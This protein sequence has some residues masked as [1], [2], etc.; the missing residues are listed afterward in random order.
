MLIILVQ[1][2][3]GF[4]FSVQTWGDTS[5]DI[6]NGEQYK[7]DQTE[8]GTMQFRG[9]VEP[10]NTANIGAPGTFIL[11]KILKDDGERVKQG[12]ALLQWDM[13]ELKRRYEHQ[14]VVLNLYKKKL[15]EYK[16]RRTVEQL[17]NL[18]KLNEVKTQIEEAESALEV[19]RGVAALG[20]GNKSRLAKL[21]QRLKRLKKIEKLINDNIRQADQ[22]KDDSKTF[23]LETKIL[24]LEHSMDDIRVL[25]DQAVTASPISGIVQALMPLAPGPVPSGVLIKILDT[26]NLL[27]SGSVW[28]NEFVL[29]KEGQEVIIRPDYMPD[30]EFKGHV[31]RKA[32]YGV[33]QNDPATGIKLSRFK[34]YIKI[35]EFS[36][37]ILPGMSVLAVVNIGDWAA[38]IPAKFVISEN[39][40]TYVFEK[41]STGY[42]KRQIK[43][44]S[45]KPGGMNLVQGVS[46]GAVLLSPPQRR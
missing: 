4:L 7:V 21:E 23:E 39:N 42:N 41:S 32:P 35:S 17:P 9:L 31:S 2:S 33:L 5:S 30:Q 22:A 8:T 3:L 16:S 43:V 10:A 40:N 20:T 14:N 25:L 37:H 11:S 19:E 1:I 15:A 6:A 34:V 38:V 27:V 36:S 18:V 28:Q 45:A 26:E 12:E 44:L 46:K 13:S 24:Q 29:L